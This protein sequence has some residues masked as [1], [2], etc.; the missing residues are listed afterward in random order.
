MIE[1]LIDVEDIDIEFDTPTRMKIINFDSET[2][3][4]LH[5]TPGSENRYRFVPPKTKDWKKMPKIFGLKV[6]LKK[7]RHKDRISINVSY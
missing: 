5:R 6:L 4:M 7:T 1:T 3:T 2:V